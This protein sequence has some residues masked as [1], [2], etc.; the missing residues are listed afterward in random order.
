M[1]P[2]S[3]LTVA[4]HVMA[5]NDPQKFLHTVAITL[6]GFGGGV[7]A[8]ILIVIG[9]K[10]LVRSGASRRVA[11]EGGNGLRD[12]FQEA[13]H[14]VVGLFFITGAFFIVGLITVIVQALSK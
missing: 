3:A 5:A 7:A 11:G 12:A 1:S 4:G 10:V 9:F 14:V 6:M 2:A 13:G 8:I